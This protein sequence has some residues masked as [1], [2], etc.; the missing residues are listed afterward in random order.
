MD[1]L[2]KKTS[3]KSTYKVIF[4]ILMDEILLN[5]VFQTN[6]VWWSLAT[7]LKRRL[8]YKIVPKSSSM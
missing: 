7:K 1:I 8:M 4:F 6:D 2:L 5:F 3:I